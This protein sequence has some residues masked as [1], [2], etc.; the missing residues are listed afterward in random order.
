MS[1]LRLLIYPLIRELLVRECEKEIGF[2][3]SSL[4]ACIV[5]TRSPLLI[6]HTYA[7]MLT[8]RIFQIVAGYEDADDC[9]LLRNDSVLKMCTST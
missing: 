1:V 9:D 3:G 6:Q 2:I 4:Y 7:D 8:Q 5:D